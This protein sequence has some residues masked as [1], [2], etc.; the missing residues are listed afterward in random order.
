MFGQRK[1]NTIIN[2]RRMSDKAKWAL[3]FLIPWLVQFAI[4]QVY[5]LIYG[6]YV[7]FTDFSLKT[8]KAVSFVG[9][10]NYRAI[11]EDPAFTNSVIATLGYSAIIIP[12]TIVF[13]L[14]IAFLLQGL[15][16]R[17]NTFSKAFIYLPGVTC[18][19]ALVIVWKFIFMP[20]SGLVYGILAKAGYPMFSLFD[21]PVTSIPILS[22]L[23]VFISLGQPVILYTAAMNNIPVTYYEASEIDGASRS[24]Q[25]FSITLPL[26]HTTNVFVTVTTTIGMFQVFV[27]PYLMTGGGPQYKTSSLLLMV[28]K[29]AFQN[30]SFGYASAIGI[31]LFLL[32]AVIAAVQFRMM[33]REV[34]EY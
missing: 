11:P 22:M 29:S 19:V 15:G 27:I 8:V 32:V 13:S 28:Y 33:R 10:D 34:V 6:T 17:F 4:F 7:S 9:F 5:P 24:K 3:I 16:S 12:L 1:N 31:F 14:W 18:T 21:S 25:F 30:G 23:T 20:G 26:M 2:S